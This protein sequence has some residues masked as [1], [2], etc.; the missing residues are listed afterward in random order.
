LLLVLFFLL[1]YL[2]V[3]EEEERYLRGRFP[4]FSEYESKVPRF[5]PALSARYSTDVPFRGD[6]FR[7]NREYQALAASV[8]ALGLLA[9]KALLFPR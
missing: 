1:F 9:A 6:L 2:P 5:W 8:A 4:E 3:I 7:R